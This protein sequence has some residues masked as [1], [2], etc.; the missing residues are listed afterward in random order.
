MEKH[1]LKKGENV[2]S[3]NTE[4]KFD[5]I[6]Y[7]VIYS[8]CLNDL[9]LFKYISSSSFNNVISVNLIVVHIVD[10]LINTHLNPTMNLM[11]KHFI[12]LWF[13]VS[14][15]WTFLC[16]KT[17]DTCCYDLDTCSNGNILN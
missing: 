13:I 7:L 14:Y 3:K 9:L 16:L 8:E 17:L 2:T 6:V 12:S 1:S 10:K 5:F 15:N 4:I 11:L